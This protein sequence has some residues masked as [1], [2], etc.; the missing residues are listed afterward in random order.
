MPRPVGRGATQGE[1][2]RRRTIFNRKESEKGPFHGFQAV[3]PES[4][5][6][7]DG[8]PVG[9]RTEKRHKMRKK[10]AK[11][12]LRA[13]QTERKIQCGKKEKVRKNAKKRRDVR[14]IVQRVFP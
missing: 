13:C 9:F 6:I 4:G 14:I 5:R 12:A 11:G 10:E 8:I 7:P 3:R 2:G 1:K